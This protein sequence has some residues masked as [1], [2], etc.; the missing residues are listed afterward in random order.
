MQLAPLSRRETEVAELVAKGLTNR[1]IAT[2]L[3]ISERT[4]ESHVEQIRNK[5]G[6]NS[7]TQIAGWM[8]ETRLRQSAPVLPVGRQKQPRPV[9]RHLTVRRRSMVIAL[10][11]LGVAAG[12]ALA[13]LVIT[14]QTPARAPIVTTVAGSGVIAFS[15]DGGRPTE[16]ALARPL[17]IALGRD[18]QLYIIDGDRVRKIGS[19]AVITVVGTGQAGYAGDGAAATAARLNAPRALAFDSQGNLYIVDTLN[20]AVRRVDPHGVIT[21]VAGTGEAGSSGDGGLA[22]LARLNSPSGVAVG[23]GGTLYIADSGNHRIRAV[24]PDGTITSFAGTGEP[25]YAGDG[26]PATSAPLNSPQGL[27]FDSEGNL[28]IADTLNDRVRRVDPEGMITTVAGSGIR[29]FAGDGG[30]ARV[31][32]LSLAAGPLESAGQA[33]TVDTQGNLYIADADNQRVRRVGL[34]GV[35]TTVAGSGQA[36]YSGDGGPPTSAAFNSPLGVAA[37]LYGHIY[38]ADTKNGR[39]RELG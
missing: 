38:I 24:A 32:A 8:V 39:I 22:T 7:R 34:N 26:G 10:A 35:I 31:A 30:P 27:A 18:D 1:E 20:N 21:T 14:M 5:L 25:R 29:G 28:Y 9:A 16:T 37:D 13:A 19:K 3:F 15:D 33:L 17:A 11:I 6:F 2:K 23:F 36:G 4:V 12:G